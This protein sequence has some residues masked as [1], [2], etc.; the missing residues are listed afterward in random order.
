MTMQCSRA[1]ERL[2]DIALGAIAAQ[3][4]ENHLT[5]CPRCARELTAIQER[6]ARLDE[7]I[8]HIASVDI[9]ADLKA[10]VA[11]RLRAASGRRRDGTNT[12]IVGTASAFAAAAIVVTGFFFAEQHAR[13]SYYEHSV[14]SAAAA[15]AQWR[16]PTDGLLVRKAV[17]HNAS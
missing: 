16:S 3:D 17:K 7:R 9:P 12:I 1:R 11:E 2:E 10:K 13:Q 6:A 8:G 5:T 4:A 15:I 14:F